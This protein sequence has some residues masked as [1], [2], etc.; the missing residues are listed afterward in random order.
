MGQYIILI[1]TFLFVKLLLSLYNEQDSKFEVAVIKGF[2]IGATF[3]EADAY[4]EDGNI[5]QEKICIFQ[6]TFG[7]LIFTV[8]Y[9]KS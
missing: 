8:T 6:V 7:C 3:Q 4:D 1:Y 5:S 2:L 9:L